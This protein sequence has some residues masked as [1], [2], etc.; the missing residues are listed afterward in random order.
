MTLACNWYNLGEMDGCGM[1]ENRFWIWHGDY[2]TRQA[3]L[4]A[5][6]QRQFKLLPEADD[7][8]E[9]SITAFNMSLPGDSPWPNPLPDDFPRP[10]LRM[11]END[12]PLACPG[13]F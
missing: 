12:S 9:E 2:E 6:R 8:L 11:P 3:L 10:V 5:Q 7:A 1:V 4:G 13:L